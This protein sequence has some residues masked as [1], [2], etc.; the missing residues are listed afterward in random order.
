MP[1]SPNLAAPA[2][3]ALA[4][5]AGLLPEG[6][7]AWGSG[8]LD[9]QRQLHEALPPAF[10]KR[11]APETEELA[12]REWSKYPDSFESFE[13]EAGLIGPEGLATLERYGVARRY[14]LHSERARAVAFLL[15]VEALRA[16]RHETALFWVANIGHSVADMPASNHDP[17][18]HLAT[19]DWSQLPLRLA[20]GGELREAVGMLDLSHVARHPEGKSAFAAAVE[21]LCL[22]D[23]GRDAR[24]ALLEIMRYGQEGAAYCAARGP[25][26]WEAA[27]A[28][29]TVD[30]PETRAALFEPVAEL[31][32]W[33]LVR[34]AR[35]FEVALRLAESGEALPEIDEALLA[36]H[37]GQ[38]DALLAERR[39]E[40]EALYSGLRRPLGETGSPA[41]GNGGAGPVGVVLEPAWRMNEGMTG[42]GDR[43]LAAM[44]C[45]TLG[46]AGRPYA[47]LDLRDVLADRLPDPAAMPVLVFAARQAGNYHAYRREALEE[48]LRRYREA[49]GAV[50]WI[51]GRGR[52]LAAPA[53]AP[54]FEQA[55]PGPWPVSAE[56]LPG[57]RLALVG[58]DA[59][60]DG[61][62]TFLRNPYT[63]AGWHRPYGPLHLPKGGASDVGIETLLELRSGDERF[64]VGAVE[65]PSAEAGEP[66]KPVVGPVAWL[67]T[68][69]LHPWLFVEAGTVEAAD[70]LRLDE[71]GARIFF[72]AL[73]R[74]A[75]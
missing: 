42:F 60:G 30:N 65:R 63:P 70:L 50:L 7:G 40:D 27:L 13:S 55:E 58:G 34:V 64:L 14:D 47:T 22:R 28:R 49:G 37:A 46:D 4:F 66:G 69:A 68:Y 38:I 56:A 51:G 36:E 41:G 67:P 21:R 10:M 73:D 19:Y 20:D 5:A 12:I 15:L 3:A 11:I 2:L 53:L 61:E 57:S 18:L 32:A 44:V 59:Q 31:G 39:L 1:R 16:G 33:A 54:A 52:P 17:L 29:A 9:W 75:P 8:H 6:A 23:D 71:A 74:I 62:W 72:E 24:A 48:A 45:R 35:D 26:I 43:V 25:R